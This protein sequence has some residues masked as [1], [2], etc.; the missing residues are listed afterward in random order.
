MLRGSIERLRGARRPARSHG[1]RTEVESGFGRLFGTVEMVRATMRSPIQKCSHG[2]GLPSRQTNTPSILRIGSM[3]WAIWPG[4]EKKCSWM[5]RSRSE[6]KM[7]KSGW[8]WYQP[9]IDSL[10]NLVS[11]SALI[12]AQVWWVKVTSANRV[13][14]PSPRI[15]SDDLHE[16]AGLV[17][18]PASD[19]DSADLDRRVERWRGARVPH[20]PRA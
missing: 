3:T 17:A 19:Q 2:L 6:R 7:P 4:P 13:S 14:A 8:V 9:T 15:D 16:R 11:I 20:G 12:L 10:V 18:M 5:K 1:P